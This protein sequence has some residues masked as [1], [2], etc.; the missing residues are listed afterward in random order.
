MAD[1]N[2]TARNL[3]SLRNDLTATYT[4]V[5]EAI[6]KLS[7]WQL[8]DALCMVRD[9]GE[10]WCEPDKTLFEKLE[11]AN[12]IE[13]ARGDSDIDIH[14]HDDASGEWDVVAMSGH[15]TVL[16]MHF[17]AYEEGKAA[18]DAL[19]AFVELLGRRGVSEWRGPRPDP[20]PQDLPF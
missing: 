4:K 3:D 8:F 2:E 1:R 17:K 13:A 18:F 7:S 15:V 5:D 16:A 12:A 14:L 19:T 6:A 9:Y 11:K 10:I 20:S